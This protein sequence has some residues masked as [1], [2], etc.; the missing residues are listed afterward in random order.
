MLKI[1]QDIF[2]KI[3][4]NESVDKEILLLPHKIDAKSYFEFM[5]ELMK[6]SLAQ[7]NLIQAQ[8]VAMHMLMI[9]ESNSDTDLNRVIISGDIDVNEGIYNMMMSQIS[10]QQR[11]FKLFRYKNILISFT[12]QCI[13]FILLFIILKLNI[14]ISVT[15]T[16]ILLGIDLYL[17]TKSNRMR[18]Q[19]KEIKLYKMDVNPYILSINKKYLVRR[20]DTD[21]HIIPR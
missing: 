9:L 7:S 21:K 6:L 19:K 3:K 5:N 10:S 2:D 11:R 14:Y 12:T 15:F 16:I 18:F 17:N 1:M 13:L 4:I 8:Y 20:E